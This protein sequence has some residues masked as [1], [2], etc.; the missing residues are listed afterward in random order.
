MENGIILGPL[1]LDK[2]NRND[3]LEKIS[4]DKHRLSLSRCQLDYR[5]F[6]KLMLL[7]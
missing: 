4:Q 6:E 7:T 5:L 2:V 3:N 1:Y